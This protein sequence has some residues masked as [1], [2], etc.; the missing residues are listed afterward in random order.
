[1]ID[2]TAHFSWYKLDMDN[3]ITDEYFK[4]PFDIHIE[5]GDYIDNIVST[6]EPREEQY[7]NYNNLNYYLL[8]PI[9]AKYFSPSDTILSNISEIEEIY[10]ILDYH[11]ICVLF[12][13]G[14][15]KITETTLCSYD[16][17]IEKANVVLEENP[18]VR[19][20]IQSDETEFI[21]RMLHQFPNRSF[22]LKDH[23]RHITKSNTTVDKSCQYSN[24][25][26][27]KY[28]LAITIIMSKCKYLVFGSGNC[29]LWIILFR[30]HADNMYQ[31]LDNDWV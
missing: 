7:S 26:F 15:D 23:I 5:D 19:F 4:L 3:D 10:N 14:N 6:L 31:F 13:R 27:S 30:G 28:Y 9:I 29:S 22:Y 8:R 2:G 24:Y 12:Y 25:I 16:D 20:L 18:N 21:K 1:M 17:I 11:N